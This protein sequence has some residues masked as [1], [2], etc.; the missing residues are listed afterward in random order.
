MRCRAPLALGLILCFLGMPL[1]NAATVGSGA[2]DTSISLAFVYAWG[3]GGFNRLVSDPSDNVIKF[4]ASGLIQHFPSLSNSA[5]TLALV[6]PD[7]TDVSNVMQVQA[8]MYAYYNSQSVAIVGYPTN[9][10]L[11]CPGLKSPGNTLNSCQ[12]Q[13]F[14][15]DYALFVYALPLFTGSQNFATRDPFFTKW[16]AFGGISGLGPTAS[17]ETMV[18]SQYGP[19]ATFQTFDQG[20]IYNITSGVLTGRLLA[21]KEPVYDLYVA[22]GGQGGTMG[23]P[24][25]EELVAAN[26]MIQ[27]TFEG[28]AIQYNPTTGIA[29]LLPP[30]AS[31]TLAPVG[32]LHLNAGDTAMVQAS[33]FSSTAGL[34]TDRT[35]AWN[36]TNGQVAQVQ[37]NG[38]SATIKAVGAGTAS[39]T[40]SSG[41][42]TSA[43]LVVTVTAVCCQIGEGA[44]TSSIQQA[45][46]NAV[47][48]NTL[49]VQLPA[50]SPVSRVGNGYVQQL[51]GTGPT[52]VSYLV[53]VPDGSIGG[54]VLSGAIL[55]AYTSLG[56]P[57]GS[58]GYPLADATPGGRQVFQQGALA[59][60]P[61][62]LVNGAILTKWASLGYETGVA[63]LPTS[64]ANSFQTFSG[65][66]GNVQ[67]FQ[68]AMI[69]APAIGTLAGQAFAI[70]EPVLTAFTAKGG[71]TGDLGAPT[72]DEHNVG[73]LRQ[74]DFEGGYIDY[75]PGTTAATSTITPRQPVISATPGTVLSGTRVHL[76]IG[77]FQNGATVRVSQTG[78]PDFLVT[79]ASGAYVWDAL[80]PTSA[81]NSLVTIKAT[82]VATNASAQGSYTILSAASSALSVSIVSG[83]Q[84]T[85]APGAQLA[86]PLVVVV[87]DQ[88]GD[89]VAGQTVAFAAAPPGALIA[90]T[91]ITDANGQAS[92]TLRLPLSEG[93]ALATAQA[94]KQVVTF[95]AKSAAFSLTNFP[96]LSQ[97]VDGTLGNGTDS[98]RQKGAL[99]TAAASIL[100][101]HQ[102]R[103]ELPQP[104][105]LA[106]PATLNTFLKAFCVFDAQANSICDGFLTFGT[107]TEQTVNLWRLGAFVGG[108]VDVQ[109]EQLDLNVARDLVASGTP[110]LLALAFVPEFPSLTPPTFLYGSHYVV[111]TGIAGD[112]SIVIADPALTYTN[113]NSYSQFS[114]G[115]NALAVRL[116]SVLHLTPQAPAS[117]GFLVATNTVAS[118]SSVAGTCGNVM[119]VAGIAASLP[120]A[121]PA[122]SAGQLFFQQ[123]DGARNLY[124]LDVNAQSPFNGSF[125]DLSANAARIVLDAPASTSSLLRHNGTKWNVGPVSTSI[126]TSGVINPASLTTQVAPGGFVSIYG[127]GLS[128]AT[129]VQIN[130]EPANIVAA[131]SFLVNAVVPLDI[132]PGTATLSVTSPHGS[133]QQSITISN[134]A[135]AIFSTGAGQ[136]AITNLNNSLN[137]PA[138]PASRG[139]AIVIYGTGFGAVSTSGGFS[140]AVDPVTAV[141][142]GVEIPASFAGLTPGVPGL[143]QANI[144]LPSTLPPGLSLPLYLKQ[145]GEV[146][147]TVTVAVQ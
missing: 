46:Q 4:G 146:S 137:T 18:T 84:Q 53:A 45:F 147:N 24:V 106:D 82:D 35:V 63:G 70:S 23:L 32:P 20:A 138:N 67:S 115:G 104:N 140:R 126:S 114:S 95:S 3:R 50:A 111:A 131:L 120:V 80:V 108:S 101:Y 130:G 55:A 9:D 109:V 116:T 40:A 105:G 42:K 57:A 91:A 10:T 128:N 83:D 136:A 12:W 11:D 78:Q 81:Q 7:L 100:R 31:I 113:L 49:T 44:P 133:A 2:P 41:G 30:V 38:L 96:A 117:S 127:A 69:V 13:P 123:C 139:S 112:G 5:V 85:G 47:T 14:T 29:V 89:P 8:S 74:Q 64:A 33:L 51:L 79:I 66:S 22:Q 60:S 1:L 21:V 72:D 73:A 94:G 54:Y 58:L 134:V 97:P 15:N 68:S 37:P 77:G 135:P 52:P 118:I 36:T 28:G 75:V 103:G 65:T 121:Q 16:S 129:S 107:S 6:K 92:A 110:V 26:G 102:M 59:G 143:Y 19:Q 93:I 90:P 61:V 87:R 25:T 99:L 48:R 43:A 34:L 145:G 98:I 132:A 88:N 142:G 17:A 119:W 125:T 144:V 122:S 56:G 124:E 62:Q 86:S 39:I 71:L 27:Q 76:V 141:I